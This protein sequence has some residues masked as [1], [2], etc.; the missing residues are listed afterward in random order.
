MQEIADLTSH[1]TGLTIFGFNENTN[2][3]DIEVRSFAPN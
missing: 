3:A 1:V 2:S